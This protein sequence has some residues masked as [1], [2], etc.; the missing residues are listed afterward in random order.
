MPTVAYLK[1]SKICIL[2]F[3]LSREL[4]SSLF[5]L[6]EEAGAFSRT[7]ASIAEFH[8]EYKAADINWSSLPLTP[9]H[10]ALTTETGGRP[11]RARP[12]ASTQDDE[13][14]EPGRLK[15]LSDVYVDAF[16]PP[17][18]PSLRLV[19]RLAV[20]LGHCLSHAERMD[21]SSETNIVAAILIKGVAAFLGEAGGDAYNTSVLAASLP[22][23]LDSTI[24]PEG[25]SSSLISQ[26]TFRSELVDGKRC[27]P[28]C[29]PT[30]HTRM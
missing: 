24:L 12:S 19:A 17:E 14:D 15:I 9:D 27:A 3:K 22:S 7:Y 5:E 10:M 1:R 26:S 18:G 29:S 21:D 13:E 23:F 16:M 28:R 11:S 20:T 4:W 2:K 30:R 25:L 6:L 8:L